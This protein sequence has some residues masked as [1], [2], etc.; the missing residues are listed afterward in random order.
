M[1]ISASAT[2]APTVLPLPSGGVAI[3]TGSIPRA[4]FA[5]ILLSAGSA[6]NLAQKPDLQGAGDTAAGTKAIQQSLQNLIA[7]LASPTS[8]P[9]KTTAPGSALSSLGVIAQATDPKAATR[10]GA[11]LRVAPKKQKRD[12]GPDLVAALAVLPRTAPQPQPLAFPALEDSGTALSALAASLALPLGASVSQ[13]S[14]T[15]SVTESSAHA[16][17]T[18]AP[19]TFQGTSA[20][21]ASPDTSKSAPDPSHLSFLLQWTRP[22]QP[23]AARS[24][25]AQP[26]ATPVPVT[27]PAEANQPATPT[28]TA[29]V[30]TVAIAQ[31]NPPDSSRL[32]PQTVTDLPVVPTATITPSDVETN[33][34]TAVALGVSQPIAKTQPGAAPVTSISQLATQQTVSTPP[35]SPKATP[36]APTV[37]RDAVASSDVQPSPS[38][39][40]PGNQPGNDQRS[41][42][43]EEDPRPP[44]PVREEARRSSTLVAAPVDETKPRVNKDAAPADSPVPASPDTTRVSA[45]TSAADTAAPTPHPQHDA[46]TPAPPTAPSPSLPPPPPKAA[47][48]SQI[49]I[50]LDSG[51]DSGGQ[52]EL[53]IRERAGEVQIAVR[54]SDQGVA[55]NLRQ[56]LGDLVKRLEPHSSAP[57]FIRQE[58]ATAEPSGQIPHHTAGSDSSRGFSYFSNDAQQQHQQQQRQRQQ[59]QPQQN[60]QS[61]AST[62]ALEEFIQD[63]NN[64]VYKS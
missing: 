48:A 57:E 20:P 41:G 1:T 64:G 21:L 3:T 9:S 52:L 14:P 36:P 27:V 18:A 46:K 34:V 44:A 54:S 4:A 50:R 38:Q 61:G 15:I 35:Q 28:G 47:A 31:V 7:S 37:F 24:F 16:P 39:G 49:A 17:A 22:V 25:P 5:S 63:L 62:A 10:L 23:A 60:A 12:D 26:T 8:S 55:T 6:P 58:T 2:A 11:T 30:D 42:S 51:N 13:R 53:R 33:A 45:Y 29:P 19:P 32:I 43:G 40:S 59:Q 56:E